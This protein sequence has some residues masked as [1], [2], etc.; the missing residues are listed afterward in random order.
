MVSDYLRIQVQIDDK[1][2]KKLPVDVIAF[3]NVDCRRHK[4][5]S[6]IILGFDEDVLEE[7]KAVKEDVN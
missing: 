4:D 5:G 6:Y 1:T 2:I 3:F 7:I